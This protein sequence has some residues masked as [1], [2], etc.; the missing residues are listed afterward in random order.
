VSDRGGQPQ[1]ATRVESPQQGGHRFPHFLPDG[2]RFLFFAAGTPTAR[3]VYAGSLDS[4]ETR[5]LFD[6]DSAP[7]FA[8]PD[9][10]LFVR[11]GTLIAQQIDLE[12]L[13]P[14]GDPVLVAERVFVGTLSSI[15]S[16]A[17][18]ASMAGPLAYRSTEAPRQ[19]IWFDRAGRQTGVLGSPDA[20]LESNPVRLSPDDRYV[21]VPRSVG[22]NV[23]LFLLEIARTSLRRLTFDTAPESNVVWSPNGDRIVFNSFRKGLNDLLE[24]SLMDPGAEK[25]LLETTENKN[26]YDWSSDGRFILYASQNAKTA[27]DLWALPLDGDRQP[28]VVANTAFE[29][30][31]GRFSPDGRWVAYQSNESGRNEIL[32]RPFPGPGGYVQVSTT[33]GT[34]PEWRADGLEIF[35]I[36]PGERLMAVPVEMNARAK[37]LTMGTPSVLCPLRPGSYYAPSRDGQR[38]LV[39]TSLEDNPTA[40]ITVV[41]NWAGRRRE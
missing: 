38:F 32:V 23:D 21:A 3:G 16:V 17:R 9:Y 14:D 5:R 12:T 10:V 24:S 36:G 19:L 37:T 41:L 11:Q 34:D 35:Y 28:L 33:G 1:E 20:A 22:A 7:V 6:S 2:R 27:R 18:S 13:E 30:R 40:P 8:P 4:K 39:N 29:E 31:S 26:A 15:A 25:L